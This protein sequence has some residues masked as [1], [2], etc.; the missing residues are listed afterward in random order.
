LTTVA[1]TNSG[2]S[3]STIGNQTTRSGVALDPVIFGVGDGEIPPTQL[4]VTASSGNSN[5]VSPAGLVLGGSGATRTLQILPTGTAGD[6]VVA[7]KVSDGALTNI[8]SFTL[9]VLSAQQGWWMDNFGVS[10]SG[11][12]VT[13]LTADPDGDGMN[14]FLEYAVGGNP[15]VGDASGKLPVATLESG[16]MRFLYS[17]PVA[18]LTYRVQ[19]NTNLADTNGWTNSSAAVTTN[20]N[21]TMN[22]VEPVGSAARRFYRLNITTP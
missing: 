21:G 2:P 15:W 13:A 22:I 11:T 19:S 18:G 12:G 6:A 4:T 20:P 9:K 7:V 8:Q 17:A 5:V 1:S 16:G 10:D 14:N 3:A